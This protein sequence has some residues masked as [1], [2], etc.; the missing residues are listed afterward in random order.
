MRNKHKCF[1]VYFNAHFF[2]CHRKNT[3][4]CSATTNL[5][6]RLALPLVCLRDADNYV[7]QNQILLDTLLAH[8]CGCHSRWLAST[9]EAR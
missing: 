9:T 1:L 5:R 6:L 3:H 4:L 2:V 8:V 7:D